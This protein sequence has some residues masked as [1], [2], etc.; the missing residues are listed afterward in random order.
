MDSANLT[1]AIA[2]AAATGI[3]ALFFAFFSG[4]FRRNVSTADAAIAEIKADVKSALTELRAVH[5]E[6]IRQV[7]TLEL[8][9]ERV[10]RIEAAAAAAHKRIDEMER[11]A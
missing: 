5:D 3:V 11:G 10:T 7:A 4:S 6:Q 2:G 1:A 9:R 8:M